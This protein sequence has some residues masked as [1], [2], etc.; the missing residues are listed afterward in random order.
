MARKKVESKADSPISRGKT[1]GVG[2]TLVRLGTA[3]M[4]NVVDLARTI[5]ARKTTRQQISMFAVGVIGIAAIVFVIILS[6]QKSASPTLIV[7]LF[8]VLA[9]VLVLLA[10]IITPGNAGDVPSGFLE[11][12]NKLKEANETNEKLLKDLEAQ[13]QLLE[14]KVAHQEHPA[15]AD[16]ESDLLKELQARRQSLEVQ[17]AQLG[18]E[19]GNLKARSRAITD[20]ATLISN[21]LQKKPRLPA[22]RWS[23]H[24]FVVEKDGSI[25]YWRETEWLAKE[26]QTLVLERMGAETP[27]DWE[28]L[29]FEAKIEGDEPHEVAVLPA[30]DDPTTKKAVLFILP[31][32]APNEVTITKVHWNWKRALPHLEE[33]NG[34]VWE[35][36]ILS[37]DT[38]PTVEFLFKLHPDLPIM[39]IDNIGQGNGK[40]VDLSA[41]KDEHGYRQYGWI[42]SKVDPGTE[43]QIRLKMAQ[44]D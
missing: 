14:L 11:A 20:A 10:G 29:K 27:M 25:A 5:L 9:L 30:Q 37:S 26:R 18:T 6:L 28:D 1:R 22:V 43:V 16:A 7:I 42:V 35:F 2:F 4:Q 21:K 41:K 33:P 38:V 15:A 8:A 3:G 40:Q 19:C 12:Y 34:D 24:T 36:D 44:S 23:K 32:L 17:V 39:N 31:E 13:R